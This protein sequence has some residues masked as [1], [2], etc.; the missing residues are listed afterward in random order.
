M[1]SEDLLKTYISFIRCLLE[2]AF[3]QTY[4]LERVQKTCLK[5]ILGREYEGYESALEVSNLESLEVRREK[6][7]LSFLGKCRLSSNRASPVNTEK[8]SSSQP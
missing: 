8:Y 2:Y 4:A 3:N 6:L 1:S 5:V 7:C